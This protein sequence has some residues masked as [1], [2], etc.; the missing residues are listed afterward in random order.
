MHEKNWPPEEEPKE[1]AERMVREGKREG[2]RIAELVNELIETTRGDGNVAEWNERLVE[3]A[4]QMG[5]PFKN[6]TPNDTPQEVARRI[7]ELARNL[8]VLEKIS[9]FLDDIAKNEE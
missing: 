1:T 7:V 3:K 9:E 8:H 2:K 6:I 5:I 4:E